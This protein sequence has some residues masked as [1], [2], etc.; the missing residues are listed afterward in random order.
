MSGPEGPVASSSRRFS[1]S[2][3]EDLARAG[4]TGDSNN[5]NSLFKELD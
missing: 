1:L 5:R 4:S 3:D 2:P